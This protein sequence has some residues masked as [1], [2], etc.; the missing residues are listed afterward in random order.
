[1]GGKMKTINEL[2]VIMKAVRERLNDLKGLRTSVSRR[3]V[4]YGQKD[5]V[6]EPQYD[7]KLVDKR[8]TELQNFLL[9]ADS[10]IKTVNAI[11]PVEIDINLNELLKPLE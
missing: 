10:K 6:E 8:I 3:T 11:T 4:F 7:V 5:S 1:M 9:E 2:L